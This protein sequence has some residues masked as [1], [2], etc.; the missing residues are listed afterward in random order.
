M[1]TI[2]RGLSSSRATHDKP[3]ISGELFVSE[4]VQFRIK[5]QPQLC[6]PDAHASSLCDGGLRSEGAQER[7]HPFVFPFFST[8][9]FSTF[10]GVA[11]SLAHSVLV[12]LP[13]AH[14]S[15]WVWP[16]AAGLSASADF[17]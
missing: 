10:T 16:A 7:T 5:P 17:L 4:V 9:G 8:F 15:V 14:E 2:Q 11:F 1:P 6:T 12:F 3:V 13:Q